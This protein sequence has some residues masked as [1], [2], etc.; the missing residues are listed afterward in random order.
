MTADEWSTILSFAETPIAEISTKY[1]ELASRGWNFDEQRRGDPWLVLV[2]KRFSAPPPDDYE[3]ELRT[4]MGN[5]W[6][7]LDPPEAQP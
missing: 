1:A 7:D 4:I 6:V 2:S 3:S 5:Y